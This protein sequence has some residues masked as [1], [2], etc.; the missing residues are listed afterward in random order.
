MLK[1]NRL[2][3]YPTEEG[4]YLRENDYSFVAVAFVTLF[5]C[6]S[7]K[8]FQLTKGGAM[9]SALI[10]NK[11]DSKYYATTKD[12]SFIIDTDGQGANPVDTVL[13]G[14]CGCIGHFARKYMREQQITCN[15]FTVKAEV[16]LT[17]DKPRLSDINIFLDMKNTILDK[18][19]SDELLKYAEKCPIHNSLKSNSNI[20]ISLG[21]PAAS[22]Q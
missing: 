21:S 5:E 17:K 7:V 11:G 19:Q 15:G 6:F 9:F 12:Y 10:E 18:K 4:R 22:E 16:E 2:P 14:L 20:K 13:A 8:T 1:G 3:D